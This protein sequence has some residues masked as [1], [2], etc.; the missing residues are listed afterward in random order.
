MKHVGR[1]GNVRGHAAYRED[2]M[3]EYYASLAVGEEEVKRGLA[4]GTLVVDTRL[5]DALRLLRLR[6]SSEARRFSIPAERSDPLDLPLPNVVDEAA[7]AVDV[8][9]LGESDVVRLQSRLDELELRLTQRRGLW[10]RP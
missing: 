6:Q 3:D 5:R 10:R 7:Y 9:T 2:R 8:A 1:Q 4:D